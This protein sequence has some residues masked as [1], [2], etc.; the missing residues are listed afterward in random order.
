MLIE[1]GISIHTTTNFAQWGAFSFLCFPAQ[2]GASCWAFSFRIDLNKGG[3]RD[4]SRN[5]SNVLL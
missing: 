2:I 1:P 4:E 3:S 5:R